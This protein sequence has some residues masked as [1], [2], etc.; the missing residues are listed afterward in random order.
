MS[1]EA[2]PAPSAPAFAA[3]HANVQAQVRPQAR[4]GFLREGN[5]RPVLNAALRLAR[6][7]RGTLALVLEAEGP[8]YAAPGAMAAFDGLQGPVAGWLTGGSMEA[9]LARRAA[10]ADAS[11][12]LEWLQF[13]GQGGGRAG[14]GEGWTGQ[15]RIALLPLRSLP[16]VEE[17]LEAWLEGGVSLRRSLSRDGRVRI[18]VDGRPLPAWHV[19]AATPAWRD[20]ASAWSLSLLRQPQVLLLGAGPET[21]PLLRLL[22][23]L[24]WRSR[25]GEHRPE[26]MPACAAAD[27]RGFDP[28]GC[29]AALVMHH[30][31][32]ADRLAL[33]RL[34]ASDV[35]FIGLLGP[36]ARRDGLL[37]QLS[38]GER[39][40][41]E[42][43]LHAPVGLDLGGRGPEAIALGIAAQLQAWR[44]GREAS[45]PDA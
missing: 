26:W 38:A 1:T 20:A 11:G 31:F 40:A 5:P 29:D 16:G 25:A 42:G 10:E 32:E 9:E 13:D 3:M 6:A 2:P 36:A 15:L 17:P 39:G 19:P 7:R 23:D 33:Q 28:S 4:S 12:H 41:L 18:E 44:S 34:A 14:A 24:G 27:S 22:R 43:R 21:P 35:P 8:T 37:G 45:A 30:A